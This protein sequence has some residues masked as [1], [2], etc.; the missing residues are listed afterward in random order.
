MLGLFA[1]S[2][3]NGDKT[4]RVIDKTAGPAVASTEDQFTGIFASSSR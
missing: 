4:A 2:S 1:G 3:I